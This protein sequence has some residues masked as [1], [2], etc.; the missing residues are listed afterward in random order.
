MFTQMDVQLIMKYQIMLTRDSHWWQMMLTFVLCLTLLRVIDRVPQPVKML[1]LV[2]NNIG[3]L[4]DVNAWFSFS[5]VLVA[6]RR[7]QVFS[8][9]TIRPSTKIN[10]CTT[11]HSGQ[12]LGTSYTSTSSNLWQKHLEC[13]HDLHWQCLQKHQHVLFTAVVRLWRGWLVWL[14]DRTCVLVL[15]PV[16]HVCLESPMLSAHAD[17]ELSSV[18]GHAQGWQCGPG[19]CWTQGIGVLKMSPLG[20]SRLRVLVIVVVG[21]NE[22]SPQLILACTSSALTSLLPWEVCP[23]PQPWGIWNDLDGKYHSRIQQH[24]EHS[25]CSSGNQWQVLKVMRKSEHWAKEI[26]N[27]CTKVNVPKMVVCYQPLTLL[28]MFTSVDEVIHFFV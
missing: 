14:M 9:I 27:L 18:P 7:G 24:E 4:L 16:W 26:R 23:M 15:A 17:V 10:G 19:V 22:G 21:L 2:G 13:S 5:E 25:A 8:E 20:E 3:Y 6:L 1:A 12:A 28:R 11:Y